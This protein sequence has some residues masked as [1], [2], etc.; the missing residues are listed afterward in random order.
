MDDIAI[1]GVSVIDSLGSNLESNWDKYLQGISPLE[2]IKKFD[3]DLFPLIKVNSAFQI[4]DDHLDTSFLTTAELKNLDR[5]S[6][7]GFC[8][9][10]A[11]ASQA[12]IINCSNTGVIYGSLGG[13]Q[14]LILDNISKM[15]DNKRVTPRHALAAQRDNLGSLICKKFGFNGLNLSM[16]SACATSIVIIDYA[17]KL[18][19]SNTY[20][21]ILVGACDVM[22]DPIDIFMFQ[23]IGA[24]DTRSPPISCPFDLDRNGFVMGEG[25][26]T[27]ILKKLDKAVENNDKIYGIIKGTGFATELYH[28]TGMDPEAIGARQSI[29]MAL[30]NANLQRDQISIISCHATSTPNGDLSEYNIIKEYF[31]NAALMALKANIGHTMAACGLIELAY[32]IQSMNMNKIGSIANLKNPID[33]IISDNYKRE[34]PNF[35]FGIKNSF[36]FGG[37]CAAVIIEKY[38]ELV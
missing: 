16:T 6:I 20:D 15:L 21:Q 2:P 3:L 12:N 9:A 14:K 5:Y 10:H 23:S 11:A 26:C 8:S 1:I 22:V 38:D 34:F 35:K 32:L 30:K 37:K 28:E 17:V 7:I 36:G 13:P 25:A 18:L 27:F 24:L 19:Q 33:K 29:D 4:D 31:P